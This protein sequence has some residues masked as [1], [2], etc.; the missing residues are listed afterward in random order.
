MM[1]RLF[2]KAEAPF[3][4]FDPPDPSSEFPQLAA[5]WQTTEVSSG[6]F[7]IN[8]QFKQ[9]FASDAPDFGHHWVSFYR[10]DSGAYWPVNYI[11]ARQ[12]GPL[13]LCGG[14]FTDG[15]AVKMMS[16]EHRQALREAGGLYYVAIRNV[17]AT[18]ADQCEA[19][20]GYTGDAHSR[21]VSAAAGFRDTEHPHLV[22]NFHPSTSPERQVELIQAAHKLGAF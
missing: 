17:V 13:I 4:F 21:K 19:F 5:F 18:M 15:A 7:F 20:M 1:K 16:R 2:N 8:S 12:Y 10:A 9:N 3:E 6:R 22:A 11:H 14:V